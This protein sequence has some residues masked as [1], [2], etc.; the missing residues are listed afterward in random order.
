MRNI[1]TGYRMPFQAG[2]ASALLSPGRCRPIQTSS[3][4]DEPTSAL[5]IFR[6]GAASLNLLVKL[7]Q[8]REPHRMRRSAHNVSVVRGALSDRV[9]V[10]YLGQIVELGTT[11]QV[12]VRPAR[13]PT[14]GCC[15]IPFPEP[16]NRWMK[17]WRCVKQSFL[18]IVTFPPAVISGT[19]VR[20]QRKGASARSRY[21]LQLRAVACAAG[22]I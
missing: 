22:A 17:T 5:D 15:L 21:S 16:A 3:V 2:S 12:L 18:A 6:A 14:P 8:E 7:Q 19:A 4:L 11:D 13:I 1:L 20:R 9:A 10:M